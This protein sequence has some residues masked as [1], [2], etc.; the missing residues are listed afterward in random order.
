MKTKEKY[1]EIYIRRM[2][3][4]YEEGREQDAEDPGY[5]ATMKFEEIA[6]TDEVVGYYVV[7]HGENAFK[8]WSRNTEGIKMTEQDKEVDKILYE[9]YG[10]ERIVTI[11][12]NPKPKNS[13]TIWIQA[14]RDN[15]AECIQAGIRMMPD[16]LRITKELFGLF[17]VK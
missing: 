11:S 10:A 6:N 5:Y 16:E 4:L 3:E 9:L 17:A 12:L 13:N 2:D 8:T 1:V 7:L 15:A 14:G